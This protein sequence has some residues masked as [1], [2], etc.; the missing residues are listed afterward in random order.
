MLSRMTQRRFHVCVYTEDMYSAAAAAACCFICS[1]A[2]AASGAAAATIDCLS[3]APFAA[4]AS[5]CLP[6]YIHVVYIIIVYMYSVCV[7]VCV[8]VCVAR[9]RRAWTARFAA[10]SAA[11]VASIALPIYTTSV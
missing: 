11:A 10:T 8:C 9:L 7:C 3:R 5:S 2:L 6:Y 1:S 4:S